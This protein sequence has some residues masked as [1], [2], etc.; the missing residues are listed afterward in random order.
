M[1]KRIIRNLCGALHWL[2]AACSGFYATIDLYLA[3]GFAV[4]SIA[5][6]GCFHLLNEMLLKGGE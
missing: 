5:F 1:N 6:L 2:A 3:A 4:I